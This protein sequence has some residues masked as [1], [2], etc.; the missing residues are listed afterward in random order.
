MATWL[1]PLSA[2]AS[3]ID[4]WTVA[5]TAVAGDGTPVASVLCAHNAAAGY[6]VLGEM[7]IVCVA[8]LKT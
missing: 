7:R 8:C 1:E 6:G 3:E 2:A 4:G 5:V